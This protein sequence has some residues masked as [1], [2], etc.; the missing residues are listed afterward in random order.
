MVAQKESSQATTQEILQ[1]HL[2]DRFWRL[3]NLY[4]ILNEQGVKVPFRMNAVQCKLYRN[5][6]WLNLIPK[7]R[8]HGITT[9]ISVF[10]L[11]A[12]LFNSDIRAGIIAH[13]LAD[14]KKIFRDK[15][16]F[17]YNHLPDDL[18]DAV[19]LLK[20]D[21]QE[22][23]F[24]NNS[25]IYVGTSMRS[26][27]LQYLHISEYGWLCAHA[28]IKAAEIKSGA[29]ETVH[30][31][32]MIFIESTA[33]GP[34]GDFAEMCDDAEQAQIE[35]RELGPMEYKLHFFSWHEKA[36]N[37][38]DP[39]YVKITPEQHEYFDKLEKIYNKTI[40]LKQRAYYIAKKKTLK[41]LIYKQHP[42]TLEEAF[43][44][45]IEGAYYAQE[46]SQA[47]EEGRICIVPH[48]PRYPVHTVCDLGIGGH[49][50][51]IFFQ[52][53][54]LEC[55]LINCFNLSKKDDVRGGAAFY[56]GMLDDKR[57]V[58]HYNYGKHF[59]PFDASKGECGTGQSIYKT[60]KEHGITFVKLPQELSVLDGIERLTNWFSSL[61]IDAEDCKPV[62]NAWASYHRVWIES[63]G[64]YD[65]KPAESEAN[66]YAD[67]G[68]YLSYILEKKLYDMS[69]EGNVTAAQVKEWEQK[70]RRA[71]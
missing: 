63:E 10:E 46:L 27:T 35:Q 57:D 18:K 48:R 47:R 44:A 36:S 39:K 26:G 2:G 40:T 24:S 53:I 58:N 3:N 41:H 51:W 70:Y 6:H 65:D 14:A 8:Q 34:I 20:D 9:F 69:G 64:Q 15:I 45:A 37:V 52:V 28:P 21:A 17:A 23:V 43:I 11:D 66:H 16:K 19:K 67:A 33:E 60:F 54:G 13:K 59:C 38:T 1:K 68:R 50:P 61:W 56:K 49:M 22:L 12:C 42:S 4:Y 31:K 55:H 62:L 71:V 5:L 30:A 25:G 32:G 7:S 29:L